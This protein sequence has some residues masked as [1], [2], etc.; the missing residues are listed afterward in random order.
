MGE[1]LLRASLIPWSHAARDLD[2]LVG[3]IA[4][5]RIVGHLVWMSAG[6]YKRSEFG[7]S[8]FWKDMRERASL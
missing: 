3:E 6:A 1:P 2:G 4:H 8:V 7:P 5:S